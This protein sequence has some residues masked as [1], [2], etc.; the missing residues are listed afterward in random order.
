MQAI[1]DN[2]R[3]R[4]VD[5][6]IHIDRDLQNINSDSHECHVRQLIDCRRQLLADL[7]SLPPDNGAA[8][9]APRPS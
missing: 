2:K 4:I 1:S 6:L 8:G 3:Q 9:N 7:K 5:D